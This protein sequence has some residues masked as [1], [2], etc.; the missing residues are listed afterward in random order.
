MSTGALA[1]LIRKVPIEILHE[2]AAKL[3]A[4]VI[5]LEG[6]ASESHGSER[7]APSSG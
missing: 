1:R 2:V 5:G 6:V 3:E 7:L 4:L